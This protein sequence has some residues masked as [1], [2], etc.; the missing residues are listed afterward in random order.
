M[1][2]AEEFPSVDQAAAVERQVKGWSR[3]KKQALIAGNFDALPALAKPGFK[4]STS[5]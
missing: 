2:W 4:P 5:S 3:L 1:V